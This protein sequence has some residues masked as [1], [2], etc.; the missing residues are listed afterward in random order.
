MLMKHNINYV[1]SKTE[2][3]GMHVCLEYLIFIGQL[4]DS[5]LSYH[6][7]SANKIIT[8]QIKVL[9]L[10]ICKKKKYCTIS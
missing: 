2:T 5:L 7:M 3:F 6:S 8:T 4:L 9:C 10:F 1:F